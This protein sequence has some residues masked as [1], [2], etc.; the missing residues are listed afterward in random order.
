MKPNAKPLKVITTLPRVQPTSA[1]LDCSFPLLE[2]LFANFWFDVG[3]EDLAAFLIDGLEFT[4]IFPDIDCESGCDRGSESSGLAH[5]WTVDRNTN[6]VGLRLR[7]VSI[8]LVTVH[9]G[10]QGMRDW[11]YRTPARDESFGRVSV[12]PQ[13]ACST[14]LHA[15]V[16]ITHASIN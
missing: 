15:N 8:R 1:H 9:H 3:C 11:I 5:C 10:R 12:S 2:H 16:G 7:A 14:Y 6:N 13:P 4:E